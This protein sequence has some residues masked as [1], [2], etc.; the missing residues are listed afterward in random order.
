[1]AHAERRT[2]AIAV[3][4][5]PPS[6]GVRMLEK[7]PEYCHFVPLLGTPVAPL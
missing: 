7:R 3:P 2:E 5:A 4:D 1:M 6:A